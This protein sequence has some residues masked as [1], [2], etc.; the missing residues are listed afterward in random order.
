MYRAGRG[1]PVCRFDLGKHGTTVPGLRP[2]RVAR[3]KEKQGPFVAT[4]YPKMNKQELARNIAHS[5]TLGPWEQN[6]VTAALLRRLP[7]AVHRLSPAIAESLIIDLPALYAPSPRIVAEHL[8]LDY[9]FN[10]VF[11]DCIKRRI[12]PSPDLTSAIMAPISAFADLD[13]PQLPTVSSLADWLLLPL[14]QLDYLA[15]LHNRF[16][17][18]GETAINHYHYNLV[19]KKTTGVRLIEAPKQTL[20]SVQRLILHGIIDKL[21]NHADA[22]GFVKGRN[23]LQAANRHAGEAIV[24]C[25]DLKDFFPSIGSGRIFGLFRCLGYPHSVARYLTALCTTTT[26]PRV[27]ARLPFDKRSRYRNPHLPQGSPASPALANHV[28]FALDQRLS[29]LA[30]RLNANYSRY[31]DDLTFSG[32]RHIVETLVQVVPQ[33]LRDEGFTAN[34]AK[35]RVMS[36]AT[37]QIVTGVVVNRHLNVT[38]RTFD[39]L[40]AIIHACRKPEDTRL[41]DPAFRASLLGQIDWVE[42]VNPSRGQKLRGLLSTAFAAK[43]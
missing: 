30:R 43:H 10:R 2:D 28:A 9:S 31:A 32:D 21:P 15:D 33:I 1:I 19:P 29:A 37:R 40:K 25:F 41:T 12:W 24:I 36:Q 38:R 20:K 34:P 26:P 42:T 16:E 18:H 6:Y 3:D 39:Q 23:C 5:L 8:S 13:V 22:F 27:L 14:D 7:V 35:T 4:D 11:D 17:D